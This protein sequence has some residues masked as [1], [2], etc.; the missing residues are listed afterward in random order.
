MYLKNLS[1]RLLLVSLLIFLPAMS[2]AN[3][4]L[5]TINKI[6]EDVKQE[7][8]P[9]PRI[10]VYDV[11]PMVKE[12]SLILKGAILSKATKEELLEKLAAIDTLIIVDRIALLPHESLGENTY[13]LIRLSTAQMRRNPGVSAELINQSMMGA[14]VRVLRNKDDDVSSW[15]F[16]C[17]TEDDYLGWMMKSSLAM[18]NRDF[19]EDWRMKDKLIVIVNY[20][21]VFEKKS[22]DSRVVSDVVRGNI[23]AITDKSWKWYEVETPD[24]RKGFIRKKFVEKKEDH[25]EDRAVTENILNTAFQYLGAPYLWGGASIKGADCSGFTQSVFK[26]NGILLPRDANM[27]VNEGEEVPLTNNL[28]H[29]QPADLLFWGRNEDRI[30]HVGIYIGDK[31]FIHSDGMVRINSF[32]PQHEE[33]NEYRT[34]TLRVARR[35]LTNN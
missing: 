16:L 1:Q 18:G 20:A 6:I 26:F 29:L 25:F 10:S 7:Y 27:Q 2:A 4:S 14:E 21:Q 32:D 5:R 3:D 22:D 31:R 28:S 8:S 24:G 30:T 35:I 19:I 17:Q 34:R 11:E 33:Y 13:G 23:L 15:W 9:D 12:D